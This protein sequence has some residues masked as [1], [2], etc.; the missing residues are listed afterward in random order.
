M[1]SNADLNKANQAKKDEFYTQIT[2][3][4]KEMRHYR[5]HFRGKVVFCNCDDPEYSNFWRYFQLNFY[6]LGLKKL[7]A[8]H[9]KESKLSYRMDIVS[10]DKGE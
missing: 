8:T 7:I 10:T 3:V 5:D 4:E 9:Y 1:A 2:D 6:E